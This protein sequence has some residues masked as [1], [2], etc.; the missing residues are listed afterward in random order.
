MPARGR[1]VRLLITPSIRPNK[2]SVVSTYHDP[3]GFDGH[4]RPQVVAISGGCFR[5][6]CCGGIRI[7]CYANDARARAQEFLDNRITN[8]S[9]GT[10]DDEHWRRCK[11]RHQLDI[12][13]LSACA[14]L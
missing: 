9:T 10:G 6:L 11:L 14:C 5:L 2:R 1:R 8:A 13:R 4:I 12:D 3:I 7:S